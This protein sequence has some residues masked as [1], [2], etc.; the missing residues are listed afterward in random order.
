MLSHNKSHHHMDGILQIEV[1]SIAHTYNIHLSFFNASFN[2][3]FN[4]MRIY[5]QLTVLVYFFNW[6]EKIF[7]GLNSTFNLNQFSLYLELHFISQL[8]LS[9]WQQSMVLHLTIILTA[10]NI[11]I[12]LT[13]N[14][15]YFWLLSLIY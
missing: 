6:T 13:K 14:V 8:H 15:K 10:K 12:K 5:N 11:Y 2:Y 7:L 4:V 1:F 9:I 3:V